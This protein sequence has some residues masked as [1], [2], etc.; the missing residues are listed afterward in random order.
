MVIS[1]P[2]TEIKFQVFGSKSSLDL[3]V[4]FFVQSLGNIVE[5]NQRIN[6]LLTTQN[7]DNNKKVNANLAIISNGKIVRCFKGTAD[8]LNNSLFLTYDFHEQE[9]ALLIE[10][11]VK[12]NL[13][14][15]MIRCARTLVSYFTRTDLRTEAKSALRGDFKFKMKFLSSIKLDDYSD[16]GKHGNITEIYKSMAFQLGQ[17]LGLMNGTELYTKETIAEEFPSLKDY[18]FRKPNDSSG[19]QNALNLFLE[20]SKILLPEMNELREIKK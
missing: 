10:G 1:K 11:L 9:H 5:N 18:L 15:K 8:E 12:R 20:K 2:N 6:V 7:F 16:F 4:C 3:D 14:L 19:L 13:D 17:T